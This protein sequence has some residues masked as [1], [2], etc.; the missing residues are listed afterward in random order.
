[1]AV[2]VVDDDPVIQLFV[3]S[4]L[5]DM[6]LESIVSDSGEGC[7]EVLEDTSRPLPSLVIL[8]ITL[9]GID[10]LET[11]ARI[12]SISGDR[13]LPIIFLTGFKEPDILSRCLSVG[14]DFIPKPFSVEMMVAKVTAHRRVS[15]LYK[16]LEGQNQDLKRFHR[17]VSRE[18]DLVE[19]IF[20]RNIEENFI[21]A[22]NLRYHT[23]PQSLFNGD[24]FVSAYGPS[25]N[26]YII[27]GDVT[28][29]GLPAAIGAL[30]IFSTFCT[31]AKKGLG[32]GSIAAELNK[33]LL[34]LLP[35]NMM[36]AACIL[37]LNSAG[38]Q[39]A[40]WSGGLPPAILA[41]Q[42]GKLLHLIEPGHCPLAMLPEHEF[43]QDIQLFKV[44]PN[45]RIYMFTDGV[46]EC[47]N[48]N[49]EMYGEGR[50]HALFDGHCEDPYEKIL[51]ELEQ[52]REGVDQDDD[53]T[54]V[55]LICAPVAVSDRA[56][57]RGAIHLLPWS[58]DIQLGPRDIRLTNP[59]TQVV[60]LLS[61]AVGVDVHQDY[62]STILSELF[63]NALDHGLLG[64]DSALKNSEEGFVEYYML[65][66]QRLD[67]LVE[68]TIDI[69]VSLSH[70]EGGSLV[71]LQVRDSGGGFEV[72]EGTGLDDDSGH[73]R[74]ITIVRALCESLQYSEG[75][76]CVTACYRL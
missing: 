66:K 22:E 37:E 48:A 16:E 42:N 28:G 53:I 21:E 31:M 69:R 29:H 67:E 6:G 71:T 62:I 47:R 27:I 3:A 68:G 8:D 17:Q 74:G 14:D 40:V 59:V 73:G 75:G 64:L 38:D 52:F 63:N 12:K 46:E 51:E 33:A 23:S 57:D 39:V 60:R 30:P 4:I 58:L 70:P 20:R 34:R 18:H 10:G 41:D 32:I 13:H 44:E 25:N 43:S 55:E 45:S 24:V 9:P 11:A 2:L 7:L 36:M 65:R 61:N 26:L 50:L 5:E 72:R 56:T 76:A 1:M 19:T 49:G 15:A 35:D 54:L